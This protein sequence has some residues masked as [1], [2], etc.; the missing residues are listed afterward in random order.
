MD[1]TLVETRHIPGDDNIQCDGLSR[2]K[3]GPDVGLREGQ[4]VRLESVTVQYIRLCD[5]RLEL[6]TVEQHMERSQGLLSVLREAHE[7][8]GY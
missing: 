4:F 8:A 6:Q 7:A 5:P 2:G 3:S 1:L